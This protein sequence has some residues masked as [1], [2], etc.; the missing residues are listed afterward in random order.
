MDHLPKFRRKP[1]IPTISTTDVKPPPSRTNGA[2]ILEQ[3]DNS[4]PQ[5]IYPPSTTTVTVTGGTPPP[6][7]DRR[8]PTP[9]KPGLRKSAFRGLHLRSSA[10]RARS[11]P[12]TTS[13][14]PSP[15]AVISPPRGGLDGAR[16]A[17][18]TT[19]TTT[20][21]NEPTKPKIPAFLDLPTP[22]R[23]PSRSPSR[24]KPSSRKRG[25]GADHDMSRLPAE[26]ENKFHELVWQERNRLALGMAPPTPTTTDPDAGAAAAAAATTTTTSN[27]D[28][29]CKWGSYKQTDLRRGVQ[30]RYFNIKPW[31]HNR[32]KLRVAP[33]ELDYVNAS[34]ISLP[35]PSNPYLPP[36]RYIAMQGPTQASLDFV[37]RMVAEQLSSPVVI[38]QLTSMFENNQPK[39]FPYLPMDDTSPP[40]TLN[41]T[42]GWNDGWSATLAFDSL[43]LLEDGAI[44]VRKLRLRVGDELEDRVVWHMLYTKWPD[45]G[46]PAVDDLASFFT[47]MRL[48]REYNAGAGEDAAPR[49]IHCS[50]GVGRTGTFITLEHLMRELET[51][52]L[53]HGGE[54]EDPIYATV[55][56]L[57]EQRRSMVQAEAQYL[58]LYQVLRKLWQD[59]YDVAEDGGGGSDG[60]SSGGEPAAKRLEVEGESSD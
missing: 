18:N 4:S 3:H 39:C 15:P 40:W 23:S 14:L 28:D 8:S 43:Q 12:T 20:T 1:K 49:I 45:F 36:L 13:S 42:D 41:E 55:D 33:D 27:T 30:D 50:A 37:W 47:L 6:T 56:C 57:R 21:T 46:V 48:S 44:E 54:Q 58:F 35:S 34:S 38:V 31:N 24:W 19:S 32:V 22:G 9:T 17:E 25:L 11:P 52:A 53:E 29:S 60:D 5:Q 59:K 7:A 16:D 2:G 10:K 26:L 51:G